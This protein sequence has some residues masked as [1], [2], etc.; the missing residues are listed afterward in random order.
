[1]QKRFVSTSTHI[2]D[3]ANPSTP[4]IRPSPPPESKPSL[5]DPNDKRTLFEKLNESKAKK[6]EAFEEAYKFS[7]DPSRC[8]PNC[9]IGNLIKRLDDSESDFLT[10]LQSEQSKEEKEKKRMEN[11][12]VDAFRKSFPLLILHS[13]SFRRSCA[14]CRAQSSI[15]TIRPPSIQDI[16]PPP[17]PPPGGKR[18]RMAVKGIL[19]KR[20]SESEGTGEVKRRRPSLTES[21]KSQ[22]IPSQSPTPKNL[23]SP[24]AIPA[25]IT[26]AVTSPKNNGTM[27]GVLAGFENYSDSDDDS[28]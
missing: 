11:E 2:L 14:K 18:P 10:H 16:I 25:P 28:E 12:Q 20:K 1:M 19:V 21:Q 9:L 7:N 22:S 27:Q 8:R 24:R 17:P 6:Q 13:P 26:V 3:A 4:P 15:E 23:G 5:P